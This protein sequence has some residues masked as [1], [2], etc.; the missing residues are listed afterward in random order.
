M[1]WDDFLPRPY[2]PDPGPGPYRLAPTGLR[3]YLD[4]PRCM[5]AEARQH[6]H[7]PP[8]VAQRECPRGAPDHCDCET[9]WGVTDYR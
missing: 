6:F 7:L 3:L 8:H 5:E 9:C 2:E 4:C 1:S